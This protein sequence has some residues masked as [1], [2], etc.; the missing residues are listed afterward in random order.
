MSLTNLG[1]VHHNLMQNKLAQKYCEQALAIQRE[2]GDR[3]SES[4]SL[5]YLGH[6][7]ADLGNLEEAAGVYRQARQLRLELGNESLSIDNLAGLARV[8]LA[9]GNQEQAVEHTK[10]IITW[11]DEHGS[12]GVE[13]PL[14]VQLTCYNVLRRE[15]NGILSDGERANALL[16]KA[17]TALL[18]KA[19]TIGDD[20]LK[21]KFL[22]NVKTNR[23][24]MGAWALQNKQ[25]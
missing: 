8:A 12:E 16:A 7:L 13:Y 22:E 23:E 20:S 25:K 11:L 9:K 10:A 17:H 5:T 21:R 14:Q 19:A 3:H 6:A 4:Y 24:I 18:E 2:I 15:T 1:L